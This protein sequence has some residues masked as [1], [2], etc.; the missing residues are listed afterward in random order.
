MGLPRNCKMHQHKGLCSGLR[1]PRANDTLTLTHFQSIAQAQ[2]HVTKPNKSTLFARKS[3]WSTSSWSHSVSA[4]PWW[5]LATSLRHPA[6]GCENGCERFRSCKQRWAETTPTSRPPEL[7]E[8]P[9]LRIREKTKIC[10]C[11]K[12][13]D[14]HH[15]MVKQ[16]LIT[17]K[18]SQNYIQLLCAL[19]LFSGMRC[20]R[21]ND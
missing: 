18:A 16:L 21:T 3:T 10:G 14:L 1:L 6:N 20:Y 13:K 2:P 11:T 4:A 9:S 17:Y 7:N 5:G 12:N 15:L 8:N 19:W